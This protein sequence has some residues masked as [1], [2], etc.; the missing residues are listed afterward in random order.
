MISPEQRWL[1]E[2]CCPIAYLWDCEEHPL[3]F[4]SI[5]SVHSV[6]DGGISTNAMEPIFSLWHISLFSRLCQMPLTVL[7]GFVTEDNFLGLLNLQT[8]Y[9]SSTW[10]RTQCGVRQNYSQLVRVCSH[11]LEK[12]FSVKREVIFSACFKETPPICCSTGGLFGQTCKILAFY[13]G[14]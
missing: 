13:P 2:L 7:L 1:T 12:L 8:S 4:P 11:E 9:S 5:S 14:C 6:P 3:L 10:Q